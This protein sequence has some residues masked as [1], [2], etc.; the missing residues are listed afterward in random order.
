MH[1]GL[2]ANAERLVLLGS[3]SLP[4]MAVQLQSYGGAPQ[5]SKQSM[6]LHCYDHS[7]QLTVVISYGGVSIY[8]L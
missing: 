7:A 5:Q 4:E 6:H 3:T 8:G 2:L 1:Q